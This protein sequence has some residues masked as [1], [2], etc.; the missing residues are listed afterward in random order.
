MIHHF[1][2]IAKI[3]K[4]FDLLRS[5]FLTQFPKKSHGQ[6]LISVDSSS[7]ESE[8]IK[9]SRVQKENFFTTKNYGPRGPPLNYLATS[10][11]QVFTVQF[12]EKLHLVSFP[13]EPENQT[14][15]DADYNGCRDWKIKLNIL[16]F[17]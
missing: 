2:N 10:G 9:L 4:Y 11:F 13:H 1:I 7:G 15:H 14:Q 17:Y 12:K 5:G 8:I 16:L 3:A 6:I